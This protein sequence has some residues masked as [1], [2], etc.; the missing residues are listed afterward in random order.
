MNKKFKCW[1][2]IK[3]VIILLLYLGILIFLLYFL[4]DYKK[5]QTSIKLCIFQTSDIHGYLE[6]VSSLHPKEVSSLSNVLAKEIEDSGGYDNCLV[7]DCGDIFQGTLEASLTKG[8]SIIYFLN[9][10]RYDLIV[11]GNHDFDFGYENLITSIDNLNADIMAA[12]LNADIQSTKEIISWKIYTKNSIRVAVIGMTS[13]Y[14]K[15]WLWGKG[16]EKYNVLSISETLKKTLPDILKEKPDLIILALHHG[17]YNS[18]RFPGPDNYLR[19]IV[20]EYPEINII[21]GGHTHQI[22][23]GELLYGNSVYVQPGAHAEYFSKVVVLINKSR[24]KLPV[25][26]TELIPVHNY[27]NKGVSLKDL[28]PKYDEIVGISKDVIND[29]G[30]PGI[31]SKM[32]KLF[33]DSIFMRV[34]VDAAM[35]TVI[36]TGSE[37]KGEI[38]SN[39]I[40]NICPYED[41]IVILSL[42]NKELTKIINEQDVYKRKYRKKLGLYWANPIENRKNIIL[43]FKKKN[44]VKVAFSSY[45]VAGAGNRYPVLKR[46]AQK[47]GVRAVDT[48]ITIRDALF[49]FFEN[50]FKD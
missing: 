7:L 35:C 40:F 23:P 32:S 41:S 37:I 24:S 6:T 18:K 12:N 34:K 8:K 42:N 3:P 29:D 31:D 9:S 11:L 36:K 2:K 21:F 30:I 1:A 49:N 44:R 26:T 5:N 19:N 50:T 48:Q 27:D 43:F 28:N 4:S 46:I 45:D 33:A 20:V 38:T 13:P 16:H 25:I 14:L 15:F 22:Y 17:L 47:K 10:L 39:D